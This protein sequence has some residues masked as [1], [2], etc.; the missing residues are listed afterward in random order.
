M[1]NS[2]VALQLGGLA[3]KAL[4]EGCEGRVMGITSRGVFLNTGRRILFVTDADYRSPYNIQLSSNRRQFDQ[5]TPADTWTYS[6][7]ELVFL[8]KDIRID[9]KGAILWQPAPAPVMETTLPEQSRRMEAILQHMLELDPGKGWLYLVET[10]D[11][12]A[13]SE[14]SLIHEM[15]ARFLDSVKNSDLEGTLKA[16]RSILGRGG[17]LTPSGDDWISGFLLY[18]ARTGQQSEFIRTLG[19]SL[20]DQAFESTTMISANRIE[21]ACQGWS[22]ELFLE[23]VDSLLVSDAEV[24]SLKIERLV[25]FGHSSGVDTCVGIGAALKIV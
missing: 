14:A 23:I 7:G 17:G 25:N 24:S 9:I 6:N 13:G 5:F 8:D 3:K 2:L 19:R 4:T 11:L 10:S 12:A 22:E 21:A 18:F 16:G 20:T 1:N 15:T